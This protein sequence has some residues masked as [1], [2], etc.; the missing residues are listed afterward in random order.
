MLS[1]FSLYDKAGKLPKNVIIGLDPW[2]FNTDVD[3]NGSNDPSLYAEFLTEK[4]GVPT[5]YEKKDLSKT[6][7]NLFDLTYFQGNIEYMLK[8]SNKSGAAQ[9]V[10]DSALYQQDTEV[11]CSD[12]SLVYD[13]E[14]RGWKQDAVDH[15]ALEVANNGMF[16]LDYYTEPDAQR[17]AIFE[18]WLQYMREKGASTS[19]SSSRPT[20][21]YLYAPLSDTEPL[22]RR[23]FGFQKAA[24]AEKIQ[25]PR[26]R[27]L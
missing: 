27:Q 24:R 4:L 14:F 25:Y 18:K 1:V 23:L 6:W 10:D 15:A 5:E 17:L 12:G 11:K 2:L 26:V 16:R 19:S 9:T 8:G 22:R 20:T 13:R 21:H 3:A 7:K